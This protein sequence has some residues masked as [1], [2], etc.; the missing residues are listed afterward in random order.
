MT[1]VADPRAELPS[2]L[3]LFKATGIA[4]V[5][6]AIVL[7][8][9]VLPAE[10]GID[11]SGIG[12]RLG[13]KA[14][15]ETENSDPVQEKLPAIAASEGSELPEALSVL[16]AVWKRDAEFRNDE[17]S[18][19]LKPGEGAE[20]KALMSVG[21]RMMFSWTTEGGAVNFDM[22]GEEMNAGKDEFTS[23]WKG[24]NEQAA[25][26]AFVAPFAGT[27]GWYWRNRGSETVTVK[28][29]TSGYYEKLFKP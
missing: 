20:I 22:H 23:Y 25:H 24:R 18:L 16:D 6:A 11:P 15:S 2:S 13:L 3:S 9:V 19:S 27:H 12:E 5:V 8:L 28:V 7:T 29:K 21:D 4:L 10:Y 14:M 26:G 1:D 17:M